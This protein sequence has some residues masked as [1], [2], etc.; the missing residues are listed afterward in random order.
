M[1]LADID[2]Y[3]EVRSQMEQLHKE[4]GILAKSKPDSPINKFKLSII[5][6]KLRAAN[7]FLIDSFRPLADFVLFDDADLPT[8][9]DVVL[10]LAQYLVGLEGWRS[11]HVEYNKADFKWYWTT[12]GS[13]KA[14]ADRPTKF[15]RT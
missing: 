8:N 9:S 14:E 10:V 13:R 11:A 7:A 4:M 5:N 3:E 12:E 15:G 6:E 2:R 1:K